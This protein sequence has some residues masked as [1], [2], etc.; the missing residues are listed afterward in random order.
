MTMKQ[1]WLS[2]WFGK[3]SRVQWVEDPVDANS[4]SFFSFPSFLSHLLCFYNTV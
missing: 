3:V 4:P 1:L 2:R